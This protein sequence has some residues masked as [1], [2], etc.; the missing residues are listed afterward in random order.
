VGAPAAGTGVVG[1]WYLNTTNGDVY[2]KT[3]TSTWTLRGNIKGP[4]GDTGATGAQGATG[5]GV[6]TPVINGQWIKGSGGAA[7]WSAIAQADLPTNFRADALTITDWNTANTNGWYTGI[8]ATNGPSTTISGAATYL[9]GLVKR[10]AGNYFVQTVW[11]YAQGTQNGQIR[12]Y[13][14]RIMGAGLWSPWEQIWPIAYA[15]SLPAAPYDGQEAILVDSLTAPT[16]QWRFRYNAGST[17]T[18]KWEFIGGAPLV[19]QPGGT[20]AITISSAYQTFGPTI[21]VLRSGIYVVDITTV[22]YSGPINAHIT[23]LT[24]FAGATPIGEQLIFAGPGSANTWTFQV[25]GRSIIML[26][27]GNIIGFGTKSDQANNWTFAD[28]ALSLTPV[29]VS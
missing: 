22:A 27:S 21:T 17:S 19:N 5:V 26:T 14:R 8:A 2:E 7:I 16:Y 4:I 3:A 6:P 15:T 9:V 29:K 23:Y 28:R 25:C 24:P 18:Y 11:D 10:A 13:Q 1:D 12:T 20:Q